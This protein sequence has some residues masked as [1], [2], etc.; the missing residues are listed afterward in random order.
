[1]L[2]DDT[3]FVIHL[4]SP[5]AAPWPFSYLC[6]IFYIMIIPLLEFFL[7]LLNIICKSYCSSIHKFF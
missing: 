4:A 3:A 1:M 6:I 2:K 5:T 7:P